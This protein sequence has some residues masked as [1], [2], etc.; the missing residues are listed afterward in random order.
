[1]VHGWTLFP[2]PTFCPKSKV[3]R[4]GT[5]HSARRALVRSDIDDKGGWIPLEN[6][7]L[8][9]AGGY[10]PLPGAWYPQ[11]YVH[12][13]LLLNILLIINQLRSLISLCLDSSLEIPTPRFLSFCS[14]VS[15]YSSRMW[16]LWISPVPKPPTLKVNSGHKTAELS[17]VSASYSSYSPASP[18]SS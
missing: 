17:S 15:D 7:A 10:I 5:L 9:V 16:S 11:A 13:I 2:H 3:N 1:M 8:R 4:V 12:P 14:S 6:T 18:S